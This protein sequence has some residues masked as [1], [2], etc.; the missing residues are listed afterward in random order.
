M[1]ADTPE[2]TP[3]AP[4]VATEVLPLV[5]TPDGVASLSVVDEVEQNVRVP[6]IAATAGTAF[7]AIT[8]V[9]TAVP[10]PVNTV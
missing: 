2:I 10:Q 3:D 1:P 8:V 4:A 6:V 7:T 9:T 5:H